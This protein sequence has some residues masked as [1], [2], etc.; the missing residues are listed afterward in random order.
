MDSP[1][2][3]VPSLGDAAALLVRSAAVQLRRAVPRRQPVAA[4]SPAASVRVAAAPRRSLVLRHVV[5]CA[6]LLLV[7]VASTAGL[8]WWS[9]QTLQ[10]RQVQLGGERDLRSS[11]ADERSLEGDLVKREETKIDSPAAASSERGPA[12]LERPTARLPTSKAKSISLDGRILAGAVIVTVLAAATGVSLLVVRHFRR[13]AAAELQVLRDSP[14][15]LG[16]L[17]DLQPTAAQEPEAAPVL[18]EE[19]PAAPD[20]PQD[21]DADGQVAAL[22][23]AALLVEQRR[24]E[25]AGVGP[26][27]LVLEPA[28]A[29]ERVPLD[30]AEPPAGASRVVD[31]PA[32]DAGAGVALKAPLAP[33][34]V[35]YDD[36]ASEAAAR[37]RIFDRRVSRRVPYVK[38]AWLWWAEQNAPVMVQDLSLTG[39]RCLLGAPAGAAA[40]AAPA[41]ADQVR[42]VFPVNGSTVKAT[43]RVQWR[44]HTPQGT[45]MGLEFIDLLADDVAAVRQLLV[46]VGD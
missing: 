26:G 5:T 43:V 37:E 7:I 12:S 2:E 22:L 44:E 36:L 13:K 15:W 31:P 33:D 25:P 46:E 30:L 1:R 11:S 18:D 42:V 45:Q 27:A 16:D 19:E 21:R 10:D 14:A 6:A 20:Q 8:T 39:L 29:G 3:P 23:D 24:V 40:P 28:V 4:G 34:P 41:L 17:P 9:W 35:S 38:P 32:A